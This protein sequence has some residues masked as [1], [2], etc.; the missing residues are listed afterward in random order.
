MLIG[1]LLGAEMEFKKVLKE[2]SAEQN[3]MVDRNIK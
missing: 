1:S 3:K 2:C